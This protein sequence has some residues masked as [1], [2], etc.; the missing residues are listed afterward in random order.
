ML[1]RFDPKLD[2]AFDPIARRTLLSRL[3]AI[4][5]PERLI[6]STE[7]MRPYET[8]GLAA[9]RSLPAAVALPADADEVAAVL[10]LCRELGAPVVDPLPELL[11]VPVEPRLVHGQ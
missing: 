4:L 1:D 6:A 8:D 10:K 3:A 11:R 7:G 9:Y 5:P 2:G